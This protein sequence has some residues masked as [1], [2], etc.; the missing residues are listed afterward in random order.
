MNDLS[1]L[2][3]ATDKSARWK[4]ERE[5]ASA[6]YDLAKIHERC[7]YLISQHEPVVSLGLD[8]EKL[9]L[10]FSFINHGDLRRLNR[11]FEE[12]GVTEARKGM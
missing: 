7:A 9:R 11:D 12:L 5:N 4:A 6:R 1:L 10:V 8:R 2:F 3:S